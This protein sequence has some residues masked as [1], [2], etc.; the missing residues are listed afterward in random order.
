MKQVQDSGCYYASSGKPLTR[1]KR[2]P[3]RGQYSFNKKTG[4]YTFSLKDKRR[5]I[6]VN[7]L[8]NVS[9]PVAKSK[10]KKTK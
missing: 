4:R 2:S 1:V 9:V 5:K 10:P 6:V 3:L 7:Y 8:E